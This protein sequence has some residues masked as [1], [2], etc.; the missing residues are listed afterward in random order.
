M[1]K[2]SSFNI[3][4][5]WLNFIFTEK[6]EEKYPAKTFKSLKEDFEKL[7]MKP[8]NQA[9]A[10]IDNMK[11]KISSW[12]EPAKFE[13]SLKLLH[14]NLSELNKYHNWSNDLTPIAQMIMLEQV[15]A[16]TEI[17]DLSIKNLTGSTQYIDIETK[18]KNFKSM[19]QEFHGLLKIWAKR[20][21]FR[22]DDRI[23]RTYWNGH[24]TVPQYGITGEI[25]RMNV[26]LNNY[27]S[28]NNSSFLPSYFLV[29]KKTLDIVCAQTWRV[30]TGNPKTLEDMFTLIHQNMIVS[31]NNLNSNI[32]ARIEKQL[33]KIIT[34]LNDTLEQKLKIEGD[35]ANISTNYNLENKILEITRNIPLRQ[36]S[37]VLNITY[38]IKTKKTKVEFSMFGDNESNRFDHI[39]IDS[40]I[41]LTN[42]GFKFTKNVNFH[43]FLTYEV[44]L[45]REDQIDNLIKSLNKSIKTTYDLDKDRAR[46]YDQLFL[47]QNRLDILSK[48]DEISFNKLIKNPILHKLILQHN[49]LLKQD[50]YISVKFN[51]SEINVLNKISLSCNVSKINKMYEDKEYPRFHNDLQKQIR[52]IRINHLN[53]T[54][55]EKDSL[56]LMLA[57]NNISK[58]DERISELDD[59]VITF[60]INDRIIGLYEKRYFTVDD[61]KFFNYKKI[62]ALTSDDIS[63]GYAISGYEKKYFTFND[64][65]NLDVRQI[66]ALTSSQAFDGYQKGCFTFDDLKDLDVAK[67]EVLSEYR[68]QGLLG[69][70]LE[71]DYI[72]NLDIESIRALTAYYRRWEYY[73]DQPFTV[74]KFK[75]LNAKQIE[76][77][78]ISSALEGYKEKHFTFDQ[79]KDLDAERIRALASDS[80][81]LGYKNG[82]FTFDQLKDLDA[83]RIRA[84]ANKYAIQGYKEKHF[85][86]DDIKNLDIER[87]E[88]LASDSAVLG[89]KNGYFTFNNL[90]D[91]SVERIKVLT[92]YFVNEGYKNGYFTFHDLKDLDIERIE[93]LAGCYPNIGYNKKYYT[94]NQL[95]DLPVEKIKVLT[96]DWAN[97]GYQYKHYKFDDLKDL[98]VGKIEVLTDFN[99][100]KLYGENKDLFDDIKNFSVD[101]IKSIASSKTTEEAKAKINQFNLQ[102]KARNIGSGIS[103]IVPN[104][105][106]NNLNTQTSTQTSNI[107]IKR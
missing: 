14:D 55:E 17:M 9:A 39:E 6:Y 66:K 105:V 30:D 103:S 33:P 25:N 100:I 70:Y 13:E 50:K 2:I 65:K 63:N 79:L 4:P 68:V 81:V 10:I 104:N 44:E 58:K 62:E 87:I 18:G 83:E 23:G 15:S 24:I 73:Q 77:L 94:F 34:T 11:S 51:E 40:L 31:V 96:S 84:L 27:K 93:T 8:I 76:A 47:M 78:T 98:D 74:D 54:Q 28:F 5:K 52:E 32:S 20:T 1:N 38:D 45:E 85:I 102:W 35:K 67:I 88:A 106:G 60:L 16:I 46:H 64:L 75:N 90:K 53:I 101:E 91:L 59:N 72:K 89:Y 29:N 86:F 71:L 43:N 97:H 107:G 69:K 26:F 12:E 99:A 95:K 22:A 57:H 82:Y 7:D 56:L 42:D 61:L 80:A 48:L 41:N 36:H 37:L 21:S 3:H 49:R 19:L 92:S